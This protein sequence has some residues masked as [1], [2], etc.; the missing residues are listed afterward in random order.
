[1]PV[2]NPFT[3]EVIAETPVSC[4]ADV[5]HAVQA[6]HKAFIGWGATP[7]LKRAAVP[8]R[9]RELLEQHFETI[10]RLVTRENGKTL[11][12]AR[13]DVR[14]GVEVIEFA[15]GIARAFGW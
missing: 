9:Y 10:A 4:A 13:G 3:G 12:E 8:F 2:H 7:A 11:A 5:D 1:L 14:R 6:A 15:C